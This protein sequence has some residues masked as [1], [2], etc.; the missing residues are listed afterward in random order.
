MKNTFALCSYLL[1]L[2][3]LL[4]LVFSNCKANQVDN[5]DELINSRSSENAPKTLSWTKEDAYIPKYY[6]TSSIGPSPSQEEQKLADKITSLPGQP[7]YGSN[8]DQYAGYVTVDPNVGRDLFY[9]FVESP[10]NSS[11]YNPLVLWLNGGPGCS[12]LGYG[13]FEELGPF[14]VNP[15]GQ[16]LYRNQFS[17]NEVANVLFLESP[18]GVGFSYAQ[19]DSQ[20]FFPTSGDKAAAKDAYVFLVNWLDRFPEYKDREI[21]ITGESYA[22]HYVPQLAYTIVVNNLF[23][24]IANQ[25]VINL[26]G[27]AIGNPWVDD[28]TG[29]K[30]LFDYLWTHALNSDQ[31]HELIETYCDFKPHQPISSICINATRN[32]FAEKGPI[33]SYNIYA[34]LCHDTSLKPS[35]TGSVYNFDP[36]SDVYVQAYLNRPEVQEALHAKPTQWSHCSFFQWKDSPVT[37]LPLIKKLIDHNINVWI[38]S[39][40]VD[41]RVSVTATRYAINVLKL[42]IVTPWY[43]WYSEN[44]IGGYAV[45]YKGL[46]FATVRGAGHMVPS[47]QPERAFNLILAFLSG[48]PSPPGSPK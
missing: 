17:W 39:G 10:A 16:T 33:D 45:Q 40:D 6:H 46:V 11:Q 3:T 37:V 4:G 7:Y 29:V 13:A 15:D 43:P 19:N 5:L 8:F 41:S 1:L 35:Q 12:S 36:C 9:Y 28:L 30:G 14:R 26:Q 34:P 25:S 44:E 24:Q 48:Y 38:Y 22:G 20:T 47:W 21:Y 18:A 42:P 27:I 31:T 2:V 32:A 23:R